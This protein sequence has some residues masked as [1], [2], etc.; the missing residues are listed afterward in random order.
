[1]SA[2]IS[3]LSFQFFSKDG[4]SYTISAKDSADNAKFGDTTYKMF[5]FYDSMVLNIIYQCAG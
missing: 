4:T 3:C 1:M 5:D 2:S